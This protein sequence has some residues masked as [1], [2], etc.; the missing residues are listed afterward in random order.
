[1]ADPVAVV[2]TIT[3]LPIAE[4]ALPAL[5]QLDGTSSTPGTGGSSITAYSWTILWKPPASTTVF[6]DP[7][8]SQ[9]RMTLDTYG[10]YLVFCEVTDDIAQTSESDPLSAPSSAMYAV[11][12]T[13]QE[14]SIKKLAAGQRDYIATVNGW[15]DAIEQLASTLDSHTIASHSDTSAT[16]AELNHLT[17]GALSYATS[18]GTDG[19]TP[20]HIHEGDTIDAATTSDRGT[21]LLG[22]AAVSAGDPKVPA[23]GR[24]AFDG[25]VNGTELS[26][27]Y[28][29]E[30]IGGWYSS[31]DGLRAHWH[32]RVHDSNLRVKSAS[33]SLRHGGSASAGG[34]TV[35]LYEMTLAQMIANNFAGAGTIA[36]LVIGAPS[37]DG[38]PTEQ[39]NDSLSYDLTQGNYIVARVT[40]SPGQVYDMGKGL[41]VSVIAH[42][43]FV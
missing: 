1:M 9:P 21:V 26:T 33:V 7:T 18:D 35:V 25:F 32:R 39:N 34:Y 40:A 2:G 31:G 13:G 43:R 4:S 14:T 20:L 3:S 12:V 8:V 5:V 28:Y 41:S 38:E 19:G 29:P 37:S 27:G 24:F 11:E 30:V 17:N 16:G 42:R 6:A 36:T 15:P 10:T 23:E 22:E